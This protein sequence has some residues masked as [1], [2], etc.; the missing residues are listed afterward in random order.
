MG[1]AEGEAAA[2]MDRE[3]E[4]ELEAPPPPPP[5]PLG[6][7]L[8]AALSEAVAVGSAK[9]LGVHVAVAPPV[10][11][12]IGGS[13]PLGEDALVEDA[14]VVAE[15]DGADE[16]AGAVEALGSTLAVVFDDADAVG[17]GGRVAELAALILEL[18]DTAA[19]GCGLGCC[20]EGISQTYVAPLASG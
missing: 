16:N 11:V 20:E 3:D 10:T 19:A 9:P 5:T 12:A 1:S 14:R 4:G 2:D 18:G 8:A 6:L 17:S 13:V 15:E 7:A